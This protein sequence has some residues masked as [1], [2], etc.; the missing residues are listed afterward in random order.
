MAS[1]GQ[2]TSETH[3]GLTV[4]EKRQFILAALPKMTRHTFPY[5]CSVF[6]VVDAKTGRHCGSGLRWMVNGRRAVVTAL[7]VIDQAKREPGG[8]AVS[9][10]YSQKPYLVHGE[11]NIDPVADLAV[12][13]L[14]DDYPCDNMAFWPPNRIDRAQENISTDYLFL[15]GFPGSHSYSSQLLQGVVN[16]SL[17]YGAMQRLD[18]LPADLGSHQFAIE[19]DPIGMFNE[20]GTSSEAVDPHGLRGSPV[21]RIGATGKPVRDWRPDDCLLV[22][23]VTQW[24]PNE[25]VLIATSI[26][27]TPEQWVV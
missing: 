22:G 6:G 1:D 20:M 5:V 14:P 21:W 23:I 2:R 7:H 18:N 3:G 10:G 16:K 24:R 17:P 11:I 26:S 27:K 12:Y 15:H 8:V 9:T 4:E 19:Y 13:F 25:N